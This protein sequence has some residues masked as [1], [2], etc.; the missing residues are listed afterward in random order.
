MIS[1]PFLVFLSFKKKYK[2]AL[3]ARFFLF[4]NPAFKDNGV[5]FHACSLGEVKSIKPLHD[6]LEGVKNISV[7]TNTGFSEADK[8]S[9]NVRFLPYELFLPF[10]IIKQKVL[11]VCEA[12]LWY[13]LFLMAKRKKTKTIL[14]NARISDNSYKS[15]LR[16]KWFYKK[17]FANIDKVF[18]QSQKDKKRLIEL[19][20]KDIVIS[21]NIK[22]FQE[23]KISKQFDKPKAY[24]ITLASTHTKEEKLILENFQIEKDMKIVIAPRHPERFDEV[25]KFLKEFSSGRNLTYHRFSKKNNF[26]SDIILIDKMGELV[27]LYAISDLVILG[28]SFV[29]SIGGHNPLEPAHFGCKLISGEKIFNQYALFDLVEN[30]KMIELKELADTVKNRNK[31]KG[32]NIKAQV[33]IEPILKELK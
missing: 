33:D 16:F 7:I 23:I 22:S 18:A 11:V 20:A 10:W 2:D 29:D 14:I 12:E 32:A 9:K 4:K 17:I 26:E 13:M 1:L 27:N 3:P 15:Y 25:D 24:M 5:W 31:L 28:G 8:I 30:Q 19:G 6:K 21:G